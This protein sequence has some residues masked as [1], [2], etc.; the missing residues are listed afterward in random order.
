MSDRFVSG[1]PGR[2]VQRVGTAC[3][4][5]QDPQKIHEPVWARIKAANQSQE[6]P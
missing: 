5:G 3:F 2:D 6:T 4:L 1:N